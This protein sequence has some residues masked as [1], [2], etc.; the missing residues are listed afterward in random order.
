MF[1]A[2]EGRAESDLAI[3]GGCQEEVRIDLGPIG[4]TQELRGRRAIS[5]LEGIGFAGWTVSGES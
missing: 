3:P 1:G 2:L 5:E 4:A